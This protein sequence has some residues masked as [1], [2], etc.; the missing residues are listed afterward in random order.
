MPPEKFS[1]SIEKKDLPKESIVQPG[2]ML[3]N[4]LKKI[5]VNPTLQTEVTWKRGD[6]EETFSLN[7]DEWRKLPVGAKV[8]VE[9][10]KITVENPGEFAEADKKKKEYT[11]IKPKISQEELIEDRV[12]QEGLV[13]VAYEIE[14]EEER[15]KAM[16]A[17]P[18]MTQ[19]SEKSMRREGASFAH[20]QIMKEY[21]S[22]EQHLNVFTTYHLLDK[23]NMEHLDQ[24]RKELSGIEGLSQKAALSI[25]PEEFRIRLEEI[26]KKQLSVVK[27]YEKLYLDS[28]KQKEDTPIK[29]KFSQEEY[30]VE[31]EEQEGSEALID[32]ADAWEET[33][34]GKGAEKATKTWNETEKQNERIKQ[35]VRKEYEKEI[36][37]T[38]MLNIK[39]LRNP[40]YVKARMDRAKNKKITL[41]EPINKEELIKETLSEYEFAKEWNKKLANYKQSPEEEALNQKMRKVAEEAV[42]KILLPFFETNEKIIE[43]LFRDKGKSNQEKFSKFTN[44][45]LDWVDGDSR[46]KELLD[47]WD[48]EAFEDIYDS[49]V[50]EQISSMACFSYQLLE[51]A[52]EKVPQWV[53]CSQKAL[54]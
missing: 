43:E 27:K 54:I 46:N 17:L 38:G 30:K 21:N 33:D 19:M 34:Y 47:K 1:S 39:L 37:E 22:S 7:S 32:E 44:L 11:P 2:E 9:N 4:V 49:S 8:K 52:R 12:A 3:W 29:P 41:F 35:E 10:G 18:V 25:T 20:I 51:V 16:S 42:E 24:M 50:E 15:M 28:L 14:K 31:R 5:G 13:D 45:L 6:S 26:G 40:P 48:R 53:N 36:V 23:K